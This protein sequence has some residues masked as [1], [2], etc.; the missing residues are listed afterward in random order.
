MDKLL[1]DSVKTEIFNKVM[2]NL[3]AYHISTWNSEPYH[4][5]QNPAEWKYR[6]I[7]SWTNTVVN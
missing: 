2:D 1:S 5:H 7:K 6:A 3:R 4:Q